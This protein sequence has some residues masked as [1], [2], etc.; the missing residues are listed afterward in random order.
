MLWNTNVIIIYRSSSP[1]FSMS[2]NNP[3]STYYLYKWQTFGSSF[4]TVRKSEDLGPHWN[5][6]VDELLQAELE[7]PAFVT[8]VSRRVLLAPTVRG[9]IFGD[10]TVAFSANL[11]LNWFLCQFIASRVYC[12]KN[13]QI[14][15]TKHGQKLISIIFHCITR[16]L[17]W[18]MFFEQRAGL[19]S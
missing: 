10:F 18:K 1:V 13:N 3:S 5:L 9:P 8:V 16:N 11:I 17:C 4:T 12:C 19:F 14:T 6:L 2:Q 15:D 7:T